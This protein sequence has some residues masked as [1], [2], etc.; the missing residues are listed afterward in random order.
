MFC[1]LRSLTIPT[2]SLRVEISQWRAASRLIRPQKRQDR[3][4]APRATPQDVYGAIY[5]EER[6]RSHDTARSDPGHSE[7][8]LEGSDLLELFGLAKIPQSDS[9]GVEIGPSGRIHIT[10]EKESRQKH[11]TALVLQ[12]APECLVERDFLSVLGSEMRSSGWKSTGGLEKS[13]GILS[14]LHR[15][16]ILRDDL[17]V[18]PM[19]YS[20]SLSPSSNW[21]LIFSDPASAKEYQDKAFQ[22]CELAQKNVPRSA[23]SSITPPPNYTVDGLRENTL[24]DYTLTT[25]WLPPSIIAFL[26]PF[27]QKFQRAIDLHDNLASKGRNGGQGFPVRIRIESHATLPLTKSSIRQILREDGENRLAEWQLVEGEDSISRV[28]GPF[29][30]K[31]LTSDEGEGDMPGNDWCIVFQ[32]AVEAKRFV[33]TWHRSV[34]P[35]VD[36][37]P[38]PDPPPLVKAECLFHGDIL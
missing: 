24:S 25:P 15:C 33:R 19:R 21:L 13:E 37:L 1:R 31:M 8:A 32:T 26:A 10:S 30:N 6:V 35:R 38:Y 29:V 23:T 28:T 18:I 5:T 16:L 3:P 11:K 7:S 14:M 4:Q 17:L 9:H 22:L 12:R 2:R 36:S 20:R 27:G 34:F